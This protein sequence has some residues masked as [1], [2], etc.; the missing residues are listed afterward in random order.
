MLTIAVISLTT[1]LAAILTFFSGFGL[2][3]ILTAVMMLYFPV[4]TAIAL[5]AIVHFSNN[6]FKLFLV[7]KNADWSVVW[8][9]GIPAI[10]AALVGSWL[11]LQMSEMPSLFEYEIGQKHFEIHPLKLLIAILL[12]AFAL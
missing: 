7:G 3:T 2:G 11:M 8:R 6:I 1:F 5:T 10:L 4:E 12:I 9:F